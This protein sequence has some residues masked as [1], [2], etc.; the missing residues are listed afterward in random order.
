MQINKE[1][2]D[3]CFKKYKNNSFNKIIE[4]AITKNGIKNA[5]YN[6]DIQRIHN[7]EFSL[8][9]EK[10]GMTNQKNS[11][12]CWIF[13]TLNILK[14]IVAEKLNLK[15]FELSQNYLLF[16]D[17]LEKANTILQLFIDNPN[18]DF[19]DRLFITFM[20]NIIGDGGYYEW[21]Q[22][23]IKKYGIVPKNIM[24]EVSNSSDTNDLNDVLQIHLVS[25]IKS[26][27]HAINAKND[28]LLAQKIKLSS[29]ERIFE[30][31]SKALGLPPEIFTFE[32][33][34]KDDKFHKI[35][36][37]TPLNFA[38]EY[39]LI[40]ELNMINLTDDPRNKHPK[41]TILKAKYFTSVLEGDKLTFIN[42][43][44]N[45]IKNAVIE[46]LQNKK[47]VW[48]DCDVAAFSDSK[49]GIMDL[50]LF[51]YEQ[52]LRPFNNLNKEDRVN[53][54]LSAPTHAMTIV[55]VDLDDNNQPLKWE[56][57]NSWGDK[58]GS[59]GYFSMSDEWFNEYVFGVIVDEKFVNSNILE[60]A[61]NNTIIELEPWDILS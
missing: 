16:W 28:F 9:T 54:R 14:P 10:L 1:F 40:D 38:K 61:K 56:I 58:V 3:N 6:N 37:I 52:T 31:C 13:A 43:T 33:R 20:D 4:N 48:F 36:D 15:E 17:K 53:Y 18:L 23:L 22:S 32:Y 27:Q 39:A 49:K 30:I 46:S 19:N 44:I 50:N 29:L 59:K 60:T 25:T 24:E 7:F 47:P 2:L 8:Q 51:S 34:D 21:A 42:T 45:E 55:G 5:T 35:K 11:G 41:N 57:E 12:R 26:I